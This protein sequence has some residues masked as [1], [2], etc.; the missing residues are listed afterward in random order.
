MEAHKV[1]IDNHQGKLL[2]GPNDL[3]IN[4]NNGG[5]YITDPIFPRGYWEAGDPRQQPWEPTRSEQAAQ[6]KG[7]HVYYLPPARGRFIE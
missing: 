4:P 6:G 3:W 7:G 2:N 1:L 5:M